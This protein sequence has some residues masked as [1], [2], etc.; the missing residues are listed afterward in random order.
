MSHPRE[1]QNRRWTLLVCMITLIVL[2]AGHIHTA[3]REESPD[4]L[5]QRLSRQWTDWREQIRTARI[6]GYR[7]IAVASSPGSELSREEFLKLYARELVPLT[8]QLDSAPHRDLSQKL[9]KLEMTSLFPR[10]SGLP[11]HRAGTGWESFLIHTGPAGTRAE[12]SSSLRH[13]TF[14]RHNGKEQ[15]YSEDTRQA[16]LLPIEGREK[17]ERIEDFLH[18]PDFRTASQVL[19]DSEDRATLVNT[20]AGS[21]FKLIV[22]PRTGFVHHDVRTLDGT[23]I[24]FERLQDSTKAADNPFPQLIAKLS[25]S[26]PRETPALR[27]ITLYLLTRIDINIDLHEDT[28]RL[29]V[30]AGTVIADYENLIP[31]PE[32]DSPTGPTARRI[33]ESTDDALNRAAQPD[34]EIAVPGKP[35]LPARRADN[36]W[37]PAFLALNASAL[38]IL[39][40]WWF[41]KRPVRFPRKT[42]GDTH[43]Q[44][45]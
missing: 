25:Y 28:Y 27:R 21:E 37:R 12:F 8:R 26:R 36:S 1:P 32:T 41:F 45:L 44:E 43:G 15:N 42:Q 38:A 5:V 9:E 16:S 13:K 31:R 22:N 24:V 35:P 17:I 20:V 3:E 19:Y 6:E 30:P 14:I 34:F 4:A 23:G 29:A 33:S 18:V 40:L 39:A 2:R 11:F 7:F 10:I